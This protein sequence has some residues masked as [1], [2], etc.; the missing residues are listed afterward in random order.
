YYWGP[1]WLLGKF[2]L[3]KLE[4]PA[5]NEQA[6]QAMMIE[7]EPTQAVAY[8]QLQVDIAVS[9]DFL[10]K[11]QKIIDFLSAYQTDSQ[12]ISDALAYQRKVI[13][14]TPSDAAV[15]FL[16]TQEERWLEWIP[17]EIAKKIKQA[18]A[19]DI[20]TITPLQ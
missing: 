19:V 4:E 8:P 1:T 14:R 20:E 9:T 3:V 13:D 2:D 10:S 12:S 6:W 18:V 7:E 17:P 15:E 11:A 5:Y 16:R